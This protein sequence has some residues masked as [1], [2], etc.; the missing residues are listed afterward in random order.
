MGLCLFFLKK[1]S[2]AKFIQEVMF[3]PDSRVAVRLHNRIAC[4]YEMVADVI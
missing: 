3:I 4:A 1:I 2:A